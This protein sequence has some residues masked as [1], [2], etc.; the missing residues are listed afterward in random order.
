MNKVLIGVNAILVAA[1]AFL[2][3][4]VNTLGHS[5]KEEVSETTKT[6]DKSATAPAKKI[7]QV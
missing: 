3:F 5:S 6:E 2:F 7:E 1:V 4:K